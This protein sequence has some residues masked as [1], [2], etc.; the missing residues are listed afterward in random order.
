MTPSTQ[1]L[2]KGKAATKE[3]EKKKSV[4]TCQQQQR[5]QQ[6]VQSGQKVRGIKEQRGSGR[7]GDNEAGARLEQAK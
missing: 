5:Q 1:I 2:P 7:E 3:K 4:R 6:G